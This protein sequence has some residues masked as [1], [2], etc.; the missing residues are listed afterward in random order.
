MEEG[1]YKVYILFSAQLDKYYTGMT[2]Q[3]ITE[4]LANHLKNHSGFTGQ[5]K[6][7]KCVYFE[8]F[9]NIHDAAIKE[10]YIKQRGAKRYISDEMENKS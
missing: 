6:D 7:W 3:T 9:K 10:K 8:N 4:R 1:D 2:S 5:S